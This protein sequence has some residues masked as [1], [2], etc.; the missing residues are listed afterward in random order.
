MNGENQYGAG[1]LRRKGFEQAARKIHR[2][3]VRVDVMDRIVRGGRANGS[4]NLRELA[5]KE[6]SKFSDHA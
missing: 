2:L 5:I 1:P 3:Q 4:E 6:R